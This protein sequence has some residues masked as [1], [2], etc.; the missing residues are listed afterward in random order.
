MMRVDAVA[1]G[2]APADGIPT[3]FPSL[4]KLLGGGVRRGDLIVLGGDVGVGKSA[5]ALAMAIR[6]RGAGTEVEFMSGEMDLARV[7]ER[8]LALEGKAPIEHIRQGTLNESMRAS[9]GAAAV[10]LRDSLPRVSRLPAGVDTLMGM[11]REMDET[12]LLVVDSLQAIPTTTLPLDDELALAVRELK[13]FAVDRGLAVLLTSH[14]P[15]LDRERSDLRPALD[16]FGAR[17]AVKQHA[18]IILGLYREELYQNAPGQEGATELA[19][20][21]NRN[22]PV[23]YVDLYFYKQWLR[24]E[25][26]VEPA[27]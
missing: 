23:S 27:R 7:L 14:L 12:A 24:F 15:Q 18:D 19:V 22:G 8:V 20:L 2:T 13:S 5:L 26:M 17:G 11:L 6:A 10:R 21:K 4:D 9:L 1:D 3:G 16:D 25:D